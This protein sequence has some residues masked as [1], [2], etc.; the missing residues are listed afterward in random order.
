MVVT[1]VNTYKPGDI[2][3]IKIHLGEP[4]NQSSV[5][6]RESTYEEYTEEKTRL[7]KEVGKRYPHENYTK[8]LAKMQGLHFYLVST[9]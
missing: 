2:F 1:S 7:W 5:V 4:C 6:I 9:D 8:E 3:P